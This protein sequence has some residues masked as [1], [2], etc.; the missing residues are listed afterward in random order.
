MVDSKRLD[1]VEE[2]VGDALLTRGH[3]LFTVTTASMVPTIR[4]GDQVE[5]RLLPTSGPALGDIVLFRDAALGLVVHR[6]VWRWRPLGRVRR[7]YT[8]GDAVPR[9]DR[10]LGPDAVMGCVARVL[11]D[12]EE[13][14]TSWFKRHWWALR[15]VL[16]LVKHRALRLWRRPRPG[17]GA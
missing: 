17:A 12:G 13:I 6:V 2:L 3:V 1:A 5:V 7:V 16:A 10:S 14:P 11:R 15:S 4:E 9:G 8:K